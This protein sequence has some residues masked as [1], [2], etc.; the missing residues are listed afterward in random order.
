MCSYLTKVSTR[1]A[2]ENILQR[3]TGSY[4]GI[5][6]M[7]LSDELYRNNVAKTL[8]RASYDGDAFLSVATFTLTN[9]G[10]KDFFTTTGTY[11]LVVDSLSTTTE[12]GNF[13]L[14]IYENVVATGGTVIPYVNVNRTPTGNELGNPVY[15]D[16]TVSD[17]GDLL[18]A[19]PFGGEA[20][21]NVRSVTKIE[22]PFILNTNTSYMFR[23]AHNGQGAKDFTV[24][25]SFFRDVT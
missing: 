6:T 5:Y 22:T 12:S 2:T 20:S 21:S 14:S 16:V 25:V 1:V 7:G 3:H 18:L 19:S 13:T 4:R 23:W 17:L 9:G 24:Q 10:T 15:T 11:P 8:L